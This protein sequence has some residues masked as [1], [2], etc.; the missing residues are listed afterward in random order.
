MKMGK[1]NQAIPKGRGYPRNNFPFP[2][3]PFPMYNPEMM[4]SWF[5]PQQRKKKQLSAKALERRQNR[6]Q[7]FKSGEVQRK[8]ESSEGVSTEPS[9]VENEPTTSKSV[10]KIKFVD[11]STQ[12]ELMDEI[13]VSYFD[14]TKKVIQEDI[15][16]S[17]KKHTHHVN[18]NHK[19]KT[20]DMQ[21]VSSVVSTSMT[22]GK[23]PQ[24]TSSA[25]AHLKGHAFSAKSSSAPIAN[26]EEAM[27]ISDTE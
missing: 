12:T 21:S 17:K 20:M 9:K 5:P 4:Q 3:F 13:P 6:T 25:T 8:R 27:L 16:L 22:N 23:D 11:V 19:N 15:R 24:A 14:P 7:K 10:V 26:D 1:N 18:P 2:M